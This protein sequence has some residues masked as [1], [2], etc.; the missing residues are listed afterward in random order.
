M[1]ELLCYSG[2]KHN[3]NLTRGQTIYPKCGKYNVDKCL[4]GLIVYTENVLL[5]WKH[6][7]DQNEP[8][9]PRTVDDN[10]TPKIFIENYVEEN[11]PKINLYPHEFT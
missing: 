7:C 11:S 1:A 5:K 4:V 2:F 10:I 9:G 3:K 8:V 6:G